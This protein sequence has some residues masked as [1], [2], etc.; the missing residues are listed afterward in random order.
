MTLMVYYFVVS[1]LNLIFFSNHLY[2]YMVNH[3]T[4]VTTCYKL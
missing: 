4:F 2:I 3:K 1:N